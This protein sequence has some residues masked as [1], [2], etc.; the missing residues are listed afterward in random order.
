[1]F[2]PE[3]IE[4]KIFKILKVE[5]N[6]AVTWRKFSLVLTVKNVFPSFYCGRS[7]TNLYCLSRFICHLSC[8]SW[9]AGSVSSSNR[10]SC[11]A[12]LGLKIQLLNVL[13]LSWFVRMALLV[14][15]FLV[16]IN[17]FNSVRSVQCSS[18]CKYCNDVKLSN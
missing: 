4:L 18:K 2:S 6:L 10:K 13:I 16:L 7:V 1:M 8:S 17:I 14:T 9:R 5:D 11:L 3:K 12:G 15:L